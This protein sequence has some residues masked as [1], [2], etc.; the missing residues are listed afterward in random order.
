MAQTPRT[1]SSHNRLALLTREVEALQ[2]ALAKPEEHVPWYK[3]QSK[4]VSVIALSVSLLSLG[5]SFWNTRNQNILT[6]QSALPATLEKIAQ[7]RVEM[8]KL[9][10]S[11]ISPAAKT[12]IYSTYNGELVFLTHYAVSLFRDRLNGDVDNVT[13]VELAH[14]AFELAASNDYAQAREF[15]EVAEQKA[16]T[17]IDRAAALRLRGNI[18]YAIGDVDAA[19]SFYARAVDIFETGDFADADL[20]TRA[21]Y[22]INTN[23]MWAQSERNLNNVD[24][25]RTRAAAAIAEA[26]RLPCGLYRS[27]M[28][29]YIQEQLA[30][31]I[32]QKCSNAVSPIKNP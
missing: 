14:I 1:S 7:A 10:E 29:R 27:S 28:E 3:E 25:W 12:A 22:N 21:Y 4:V 6:A 13:S 24:Q 26:Q 11:N 17:I 9:Q 23:I 5:F 16:R 30:V 19:R 15:A 20:N 8:V 18:E 2:A 32:L 31:P